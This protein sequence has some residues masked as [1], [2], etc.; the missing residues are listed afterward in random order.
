MKCVYHR[1]KQKIHL[2][3]Q[4]VF[5]AN[6]ILMTN[7]PA[8]GL[9]QYFKSKLSCASCLRSWAT[10]L[11]LRKYPSNN[12]QVQSCKPTNARKIKSEDYLPTQAVTVT[13]GNI[14]DI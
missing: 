5:K 7:T 12:V 2:E 4:R 11:I 6:L 1:E 3:L 14:S 10:G 8:P 9:A 13:R